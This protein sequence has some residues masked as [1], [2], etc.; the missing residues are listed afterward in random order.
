MFLIGLIVGPA[1]GFLAGDFLSGRGLDG[2]AYAAIV[3]AVSF[4]ALVIPGGGLELRSGLVFGFVLGALLS[5]TPA[6]LSTTE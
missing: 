2:W 3:A 1:L 5:V 6:G 4:L